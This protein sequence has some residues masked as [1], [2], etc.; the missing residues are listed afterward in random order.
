MRTGVYFG[1]EGCDQ[2]LASSILVRSLLETGRTLWLRFE[3][4][5]KFMQG[6]PFEVG[7][8][9]IWT[10][11]FSCVDTGFMCPFH[12]VSEGSRIIFHFF[13]RNLQVSQPSRIFI[14]IH[15]TAF[16]RFISVV[17]SAHSRFCIVI[18]HE[19]NLRVLSNRLRY[20]F[21]AVHCNKSVRFWRLEKLH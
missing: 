1:M 4:K 16:F 15:W 3:A 12:R 10:R 17:R 2:R 5:F 13:V 19:S 20:G 11:N 8:G 18:F 21:E 7:L 6:Q 14:K 9:C